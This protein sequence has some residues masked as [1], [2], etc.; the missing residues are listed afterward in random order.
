MATAV[1]QIT[2]L[3]CLFKMYN[4][5]CSGSYSEKPPMHGFS[6]IIYLFKGSYLRKYDAFPSE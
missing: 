1:K 2:S 6:H 4:R 3:P 5:Q